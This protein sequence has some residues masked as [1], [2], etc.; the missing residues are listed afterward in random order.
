MHSTFALSIASFPSDLVSYPDHFS[1]K[2][3]GYEATSGLGMGL[4]VAWV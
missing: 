4:Q 3:P 2:W 1:Y